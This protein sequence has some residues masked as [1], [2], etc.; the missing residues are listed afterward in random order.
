MIM[1]KKL[2]LHVCCAPCGTYISRDRLAPEYDLTWYFYNSN[3]DSREEYE[4]RLSYVRQMAEKF[5]WP[6]VV[7]PYDHQAWLTAVA[8][9]EGDPEGGARC[10]ICY[11]DRLDK[12]ARYARENGFDLFGTTLLVSP[13]KDVAAI[14][15]ISGGLATEQRIAFLDADFQAD[16]GYKKSQELAKELGIYRQK[17]CGCEFSRSPKRSA[18]ALAAATAAIVFAF[19]FFSFASPV[20]ADDQLDSDGDGYSDEAEM[21]S[22]YSP[23]NA[24]PVKADKSDVDNDDLNDSWE[25]FLHTDPNNPDSDGDGY[26]DGQEVDMAYSPLATTSERL[27]RQINIDL[28]NQK[29]SYLVAGRAWKTFTVST[30]KPSMPTPSGTYKILN[31]AVKAWSNK[32]GLW[33]PYWLGLHNGEFGIHELPIWPSGYREGED[34]LGKPVSHGCIRLGIGAAP[35]I[36]ERVEI[37]TAVVIK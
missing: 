9:R 33:M 10:R 22:G 14:R 21:A 36:Y 16:D 17:F 15:A 31:K 25:I 12:T 27:A 13:Y 35:Y 37:G 24:S 6:L 34:H 23:F 7:E 28:K 20:K 19:L 2:L 1:K 5:S 3:L 4:K 29:L 26:K 18:G 30:G 32:Y 11:R 8:G